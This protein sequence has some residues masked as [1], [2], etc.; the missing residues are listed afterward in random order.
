MWSWG[1]TRNRKDGV[2]PDDGNAQ[3]DGRRGPSPKM[4]H[5]ARS[6]FGQK[7]D[8]LAVGVLMGS[9]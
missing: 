7:N 1:E 8:D 6:G 4:G 3:T 5:R 2:V 9:I